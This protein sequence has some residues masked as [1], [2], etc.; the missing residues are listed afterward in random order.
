ML[1]LQRVIILVAAKG[2]ISSPYELKCLRRTL[3]IAMAAVNQQ[4]FV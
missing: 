4:T 2:D 3:V 1:I